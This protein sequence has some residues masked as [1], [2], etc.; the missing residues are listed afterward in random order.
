M[1]GDLTQDELAQ[2]TGIDRSLISAWENGRRGMEE[3]NA[4][5]MATALGV[6]PEEILQLGEER[7]VVAELAAQL[8]E[9]DRRVALLESER[10]TGP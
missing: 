9:L 5:K 2:R 10:A 6:D 3:A 1:R 8:G 7:G 4:V